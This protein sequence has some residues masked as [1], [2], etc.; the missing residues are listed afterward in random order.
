VFAV[1]AGLSLREFARREGCSDTLVR[2][3]IKQG[4]LRLSGGGKLDPAL[5]GSPWRETNRRANPSA[6]STANQSGGSHPPDGDFEVEDATDEFL[7]DF[8]SKLLSGKFATEADAIRVKENGLA[9]KHLLDARRKAGD[10]VDVETAKSVL[11]ESARAERDAWLNFPSRV[12]P[13]MAADLGLEP[14]P[15]IE[16]LTAHVHQQLAE[17]GEPEADFAAADSATEA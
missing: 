8:V 4:K 14:E 10:L 7:D 2:K 5:V 3:A 16:A 15:I 12:G 17:L 9:L 1:F 13:L 6:N 11:F